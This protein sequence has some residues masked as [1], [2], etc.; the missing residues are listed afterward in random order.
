[1]ASIEHKIKLSSNITVPQILGRK[2]LASFQVIEWLLAKYDVPILFLAWCMFYVIVLKDKNEFDNLVE[3]SDMEDRE[4]QLIQLP[5]NKAD[6]YSTG[7]W[8]P[9]R[10]KE[11]RNYHAGPEIID[12]DQSSDFKSYLNRFFFT[13]FCN[14]GLYRPIFVGDLREFASF[15]HNAQCSFC[16]FQT[17]V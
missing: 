15:S 3:I 17:W 12:R 13:I 8:N 16:Y 6:D 9:G 4:M 5:W 10:L 11:I 7:I 1:M 14:K 2:S